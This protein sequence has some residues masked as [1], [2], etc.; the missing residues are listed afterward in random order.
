MMTPQRIAISGLALGA[1]L[2]ATTALAKPLYITVPRSYGTDENPV[3]EVAFAGR[4]PVELR[5]LKPQDLDPWVRA[6]SNLR[7][8]YDAPVT[9]LNP[10]RY[11][12]R[13]LNVLR[14]PAEYLLL[15]LDP[16][17]R[18]AVAPGLPARLAADSKGPLR[19]AE[20]PAKL[21]SIPD[22]M[23][24]VRRHW[25]NLDLGGPPRAFNVP[26]FTPDFVDSGFEQRRVVMD[27]LP[28]G[29]YVLQLVQERI[30]GQVILVVSEQ[31]VQVKQTDGRVLVRVA[32]R[33]KRP[34]ASVAVQVFVAGGEALS[35]TTNADGEAF[36][37]A[38]EPRLVVL[39]RQGD[40]VA[41]TDTDFYSALAVSPD[42]FLYSDRPLYKPGDTAQFRGLLRQPD[43]FL[44]R[45]FTPRSKKVAIDLIAAD[46]VAKTIKAEVDDFGSFHGALAIPS[47]L[48]TGVLRLIARVDKNEHQAEARVQE[49]VK[50]TFYLELESEQET[51]QPGA[52]LVAT[53]KAKRYAGGVPANT[54]YEVFLYRTVLTT[55][56]WV[57]DSGLAGKGSAVTYGSQSTTEG[58]L[59]VP[60]R[61]YSSVAERGVTDD[62]WASAPVFD[63]QGEAHIE[64]EVPALEAGEDRLPFKYNL[65]VRARDDQETFA[66][67][68]RAF[69]FASSEVMGSLRPSAKL[70]LEG[71]EAKLS[72]RSTTLS[73]KALAG[74]PGEVLFLLRRADGVEKE[75][76]RQSFVTDE[77]GVWR[78]TIP[79][80]GVGAVSMQVTLRD[81]QGRPWQ[82]ESSMLVAGQGGDMVQKV[83]TLMV[84]TLGGVL[85]P[86]DT[87]ELV[88]LLPEGWGEGGSE[89]G[90]LWVTLEGSTIY[91]TRRVQVKGYTVVHR[92]EVEKR[93]GSA[94]Y[95]SVAYPT[96]AGRWEERVTSFR[97]VPAERTLQVEIQPRLLETSPGANQTLDL[98]VRDHRGQG[99][100]AQLSVGVVD[101]AI[102]ALQPEF[103]PG[104]LEFFYPLTRNNVSSFF[105]NEFQGYGYGE[106]LARAALHLGGQRFAAV[107]PPT[108]KAEDENKD[109]AYW[110]ADVR[111]DDDGHASVRFTLPG[112]QTLWVITAVAADATGRFGENTAEFATRGAL[113]LVAALPQFLRAGDQAQGSVRVARGQ[114]GK[115]QTV[116]LKVELGG[117]L[118]R[119]EVAQ[120]VALPASGET[121]VPFEL[122]ADQAGQATISI[123]AKGSAN[124]VADRRVVEVLPAMVEDTITVSRYGGGELALDLPDGAQVAS[125]ELRLAPSTVELALASVHELLQYPYGCLEQL[126]ATTVPNVAVYRTLDKMKALDGLDAESRAL[127]IEARSRSVQGIDRILDLATKEGGFTWF[128]GYSTPSL[129]LTLIA[130][131]GLAQAVPAGLVD[132]RDARIQAGL[133]WLE[134]QGDMPVELDA[135][136]VYVMA[137]YQGAKAAPLVRALL[138]KTPPEDLYATAMAALAAEQAG[139][140]KEEAVTLRVA[141]LAR[142][143]QKGLA[144]FASWQP[145]SPDAFWQYPLRRV[146]LVALLAHAASLGAIDE[147]AT[148]QGLLQL[149]AEAGELSTFERS[150][151]LLHSLWLLERDAKAMRA[152]TPPTVQ[153]AGTPKVAFRPRGA[154]LAATLNNSTRRVT[155][156]ELAAVATL[157]ARVQV[158]VDKVKATANGMQVQRS[159]FVITEQGLRPLSAG[160]PIPQGSEVYVQLQLDAHEGQ[161]WR[162]LRSAYYVVTDAVPAG[163]VPLIEDKRFEAAPYDA[164]LRHEALRQRSLSPSRATFFFEEAAWWSKSPRIVGYVMRAQFPGHFA[165]PPAEI[166]DMYA[167]RV[168]GRSVASSLIIQAPTKP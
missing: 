146:G 118:T 113:N 56:S 25:L 72:V 58:G 48:D 144:R 27:P 111:T 152:M 122:I 95:A 81:K 153:A 151:F 52:K 32:G 75:L 35:A 42:V 160:E 29:V 117:V 26:G 127:L 23:T 28:A 139:I 1:L 82:G 138:Q 57:D 119:A 99:V 114:K 147:Q 53:V 69:F 156:P 7:R 4:A 120:Q 60:K 16:E 150:M 168:R 96:P 103:R 3:A 85:S 84:E 83:P 62:P 33:D 102:Y 54:H 137:Q 41:L 64:I 143:T 142:A 10:G 89:R 155:L 101:K 66:N 71:A 149:V 39:T 105:S 74:A 158:P 51:V 112:N 45:L 5:V 136:R 9:T 121:V 47:G 159:Y 63:A 14:S 131:N 154:G 128:H 88:V 43:G 87:A 38:S 70:V 161:E 125:L 166:Q 59:S 163:F 141:E 108:K 93:F 162:G 94:I 11:L 129:P 164:V 50:P 76:D 135:T 77:A 130:L 92:F 19:M 98:Q 106:V 116:D 97:I 109:T 44:A 140:I 107:K 100:A 167:P 86:G 30:E 134:E 104:V 61:L 78:G 132:V 2:T 21:I 15:A 157:R 18:E 110:N 67:A 68:S 115:D 36:V 126:V 79:T 40:D 91:D 46:R 73:G 8:V 20:G 165:A 65:T 13:G 34:R 6:Q 123:A 12:S 80:R 90:S 124:Q 133:R 24:L 145:A 49:Y 37:D 17:F 22:G 55:P 148:R 31:T